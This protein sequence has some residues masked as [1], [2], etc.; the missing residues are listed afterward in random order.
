MR[1]MC[2]EL[3]FLMLGPFYYDPP[4]PL[5]QTVQR[6]ICWLRGES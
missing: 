5:P 1:F 6:I 2:F 4:F 3:D